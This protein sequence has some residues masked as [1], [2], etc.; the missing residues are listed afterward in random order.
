MVWS[1]EVQP[2]PRECYIVLLD[3]VG[4]AGVRRRVLGK[5]GGCTSDVLYI[6]EQAPW[7]KPFSTV[8]TF[9]CAAHS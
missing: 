7:M 2:E 4:V 1:T 5:V 6:E 8:C 3:E 9:P